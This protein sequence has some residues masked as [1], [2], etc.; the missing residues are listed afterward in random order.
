MPR[1]CKCRRIAG[2]PK[3]SYFKPR[4]VPLC[5]LEEVPLS[6][7][8]LEAIRLAD[9]EGLTMEEAALR[10]DVSRHTFGRILKKARRCVARALIHGH[11]LRV[12]GGHFTTENGTAPQSHPAGK[13]DV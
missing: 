3:A 7:D 10:M 2:I 6:V 8:G 11:A 12:E 1:P 13:Q 4:G 9:L 5:D